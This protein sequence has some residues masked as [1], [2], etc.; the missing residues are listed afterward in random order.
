MN[1][2]EKQEYKKPEIVE[3]SINLHTFAPGGKGTLQ[4]ESNQMMDTGIRPS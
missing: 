1:T 4:S 2:V 3:F